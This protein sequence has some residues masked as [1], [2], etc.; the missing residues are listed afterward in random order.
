ME[1]KL[2][3]IKAG[4]AKRHKLPRMFAGVSL[5]ES[6]TAKFIYGHGTVESARTG[7]CCICARELTHP[8]SITLG[9]GPVCGSHYWDWNLVGGFSE[10]NVARL[11]A[12]IGTLMKNMKVDGWIPK[13]AIISANVIDEVITPPSDHH[14]L[15]REIAVEKGKKATL[16]RKKSG[17]LL[18]KIEFPYDINLIN[19]VKGIPGRRYHPEHKFWT[20]PLGLDAVKKLKALGFDIDPN[21]EEYLSKTEVDIDALAPIEQIEGLKKEL[22]PFQKKGVAFIEAKKGRAL[23]ADEMGLG[24]TVQALAWLQLHPELRPALIVVPA[25][26]KL[27]WDREAK[28]WMTDPKI[29][30]LSGQNSD[31]GIN[32]EAE[33]VI[34]NYDILKYWADV[35][36]EYPFKVLIADEVHYVKNNSAG[37][38]KALKKVAKNIPHFIGL[39][40]FWDYVR[41]Y[42]NAVNNGYGWDFSGAANTQELHNRLVGS[43]MIRRKKE[44][45]LEDLPAKTR[46]FIPTPMST[47]EFKEY[48]QAEKDFIGWVRR[49]KGKEAAEKASNAA[50]LTSIEGLKQLAVKAK[51]AHILNWI[52]N[53]LDSDEKL[54]VFATHREII[55]FLMLGF[56]SRAVKIDGTIHPRERQAA[57]D[58]FQ[59]DP[60][61]RLFVGNIQAAGVGITLTAA[62]NVAFIELPWTP[63]DLVQAEDRCH[64]IG[65]K[66][67]VN[68][69]YLL[70]AGTIEE[71]IAN[72][73]DR[74]RVVLDSILDGVIPSE[75]TL[76]TQLIDSYMKEEA[77]L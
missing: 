73:L 46:S 67:A 65:Q 32:P 68:I 47:E 8:V 35:I 34:I 15:Q 71:R 51:L 24:K 12:E 66:E 70:A 2:Y 28:D 50:T 43:I 42:C 57:I 36:R 75:D 62:S 59:T 55:D 54:V 74:K 53:F 38:T 64:R 25:S 41:T 45:V 72:L 31:F 61:V 26:L 19:S 69:Y 60:G 6:P 22:F 11:K 5:A 39:S 30:M 16:A 20:C 18:I 9:I 1:T 58:R 17:E 21:L 40:G 52:T 63:G 49:S 4:F 56:G 14:I 77:Y 27:N 29:V 13:W 48:M 7:R 44:E 37:R 23:I 33:I 76:L 10:E 3:E